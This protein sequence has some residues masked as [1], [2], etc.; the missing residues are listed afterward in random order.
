MAEMFTIMRAGLTFLSLRSKSHLV[1]TK[2]DI[3]LKEKETTK[4]A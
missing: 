1:K 3:F 4:T 2:K